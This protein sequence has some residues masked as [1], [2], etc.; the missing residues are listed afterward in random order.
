MIPLA[1]VLAVALA[2]LLVLVVAVIALARQVKRVV[3]SIAAFQQELDPV[4]REIRSDADRASRRL[5]ELQQ[6]GR[7]AGSRGRHP[8]VVPVD[9]DAP[10]LPG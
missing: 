6:Q 4:L 1:F 10:D 5:V 9:P 3:A 7:A 8:R 2:T